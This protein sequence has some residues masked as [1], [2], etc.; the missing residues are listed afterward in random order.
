MKFEQF[1]SQNFPRVMMTL[2]A[3]TIF[4]LTDLPFIPTRLS[5]T[6]LLVNMFHLALNSRLVTCAKATDTWLDRDRKHQKNGYW[7]ACTGV[8]E[9]RGFEI[10]KFPQAKLA[11]LI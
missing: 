2:V 3:T 7:H 10:E 1:Q 4:L 6:R 5:L 8:S 11:S 9:D